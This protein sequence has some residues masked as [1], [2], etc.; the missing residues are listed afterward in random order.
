MGNTGKQINYKRVNAIH[1]KTG[2][3]RIGLLNPETQEI[4]FSDGTIVSIDEVE[5]NTV[6]KSSNPNEKE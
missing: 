4:S 1:P 6:F 2:E 3:N 5:I